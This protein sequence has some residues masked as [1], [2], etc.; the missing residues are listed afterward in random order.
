MKKL[1]EA[2][3]EDQ[4][5][6]IGSCSSISEA[7]TDEEI[8]ECL[9][10]K[11]ITTKNGALKWAHDTEELFLSCLTTNFDLYDE[12]TVKTFFEARKKYNYE[13]E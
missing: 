8:L 1:L 9:E 2:I 6:G 12:S 11:N 5:V 7:Y 13:E 3:R 4:L 10:E